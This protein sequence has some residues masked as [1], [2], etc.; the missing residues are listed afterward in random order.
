M[1]Q[2][3]QNDVMKFEFPEPT[4]LEGVKSMSKSILRMKHIYFT[5]PTRDK[6]TI[7][8]VSLEC[9]RISRVAVIGANGAGKSTA[10][11]VLIG[12]LKPSEGEMWKHPNARI[13]YIAQHA[14]QHLEKHIHKTATQYILWRFAGNDDKENIDFL[15]KEESKEEE[16]PKKKFMMNPKDLTEL[17]DQR[18]FKIK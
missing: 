17:K 5:Y 2:S 12:E 1:R 11:K 16:T 8:D 6:P 15:H 10:I 14:F 13:A 4:P 9:S 18:E 3:I 7:M